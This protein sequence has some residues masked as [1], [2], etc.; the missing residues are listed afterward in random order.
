MVITAQVRVL[1]V[2][3]AGESREILRRALGFDVAIDVVG[4]ADSGKAA[5]RE[6]ESLKPDVVLM[7]VRMPNGDGV[8]ATREITRR[9]PST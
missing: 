9:F 5:V 4:E 8:T 1:V 3:D 2:D 7:D 6:T